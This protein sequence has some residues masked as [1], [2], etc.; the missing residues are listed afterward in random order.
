MTDERQLMDLRTRALASYH[1]CRALLGIVSAPADSVLRR[2]ALMRWRLARS[3]EARLHS[4][5]SFRRR[6]GPSLGERAEHALLRLQ[7]RFA[8]DG[9][10]AM[11]AWLDQDS[12]QLIDDVRHL[13]ARA[14]SEADAELLGARLVE[15]LQASRA[16]VASQTALLRECAQGWQ[17]FLPGRP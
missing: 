16:T 9:E 12:D 7:L 17:T 10:A 6:I 11:L 14:R 13:R 8:A 15:L 1:A 4:R 3:L 2:S 5:P